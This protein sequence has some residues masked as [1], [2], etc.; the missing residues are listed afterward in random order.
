MLVEQ[1]GPYAMQLRHDRQYVSQNNIYTI[2]VIGGGFGAARLMY[3]TALYVFL[4]YK[5]HTLTLLACLLSSPPRRRYRVIKTC[6]KRICAR[7]ARRKLKKRLTSGSF[8]RAGLAD[9]SPLLHTVPESP[10]GGRAGDAPHVGYG[11]SEAAAWAGAR[12]STGPYVRARVDLLHRSAGD[13]L[14]GSG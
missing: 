12:K 13:M 9:S 5:W 6:T 11:S 7:M 2:G 8:N 14:H 4:A 1:V 10:T 3:A